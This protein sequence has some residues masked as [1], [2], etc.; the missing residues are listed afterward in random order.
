MAEKRANEEQRG[1]RPKRSAR[2]RQAPVRFSF[3]EAHG[4]DQRFLKAM[5]KEAAKDVDSDWDEGLSE[6]EEQWEQEGS[7]VDES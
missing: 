6:E 2:A 3:D 1:G 7:E 5:E 4:Y